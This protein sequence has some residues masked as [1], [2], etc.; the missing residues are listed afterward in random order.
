MPGNP[1]IVM[2]GDLEVEF[3]G[4]STLHDISRLV[5]TFEEVE[6]VDLDRFTI[7]D[8]EPY[9]FDFATFSPK[10]HTITLHS[11][12]LDVEGTLMMFVGQCILFYGINGENK[13][14]NVSENQT[15]VNYAQKI[16]ELD[17]LIIS[18]EN[19]GK[20]KPLTPH[21]E[22]SDETNNDFSD[23]LYEFEEDDSDRIDIQQMVND[24]C[25]RN[26]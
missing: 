9:E 1:N 22:Y 19:S 4:N 18:Y 26:P 12:D 23:D 20:I 13:N 25:E 7:E 5:R 8:Y 11:D 17:E 15:L 21:E 3:L 14:K 24:Y 6:S 10:K 2:I 16:L